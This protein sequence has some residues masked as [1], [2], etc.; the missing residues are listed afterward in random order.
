[1][2]GTSQINVTGTSPGAAPD[3]GQSTQVTLVVN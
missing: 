2:T 1:V 3:A